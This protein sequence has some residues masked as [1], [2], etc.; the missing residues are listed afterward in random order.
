MPDPQEIARHY[1]DAWNEAEP[2]RRMALLKETW[3]P[4]ATYVDPVMKGAGLDEIS[5]LIGGVHQRFP[6][7]AFRLIGEPNGHGDQVRFSW[8]LGPDGQEPPI[9]GS[10]VAVLQAGRLRSVIGFL[11]QVPAA[12]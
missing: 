12:A 2:G 10:D 5:G 3:T 11:D 1:I 8:A 6:G 7:F 4:D 9:K